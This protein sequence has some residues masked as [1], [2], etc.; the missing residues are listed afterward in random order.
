MTDMVMMK[1]GYM[2]SLDNLSVVVT[3]MPRFMKALGLGAKNTYSQRRD[4]PN[5]NLF[6]KETIPEE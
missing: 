5:L 1:C 4:K 6:T 2:R 3:I